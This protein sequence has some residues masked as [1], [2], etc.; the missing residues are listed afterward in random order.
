MITNI[1]DNIQNL[2]QL[3]AFV[4]E[5][6]GSDEYGQEFMA[7]G[8]METLPTFGGEE[9]DDTTGIWSW[10]ETH[11]LVQKSAGYDLVRRDEFET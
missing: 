2:R 7:N 6:G 11:F 1:P 9:P 4:N 10:D 3:C 5:H 8:L